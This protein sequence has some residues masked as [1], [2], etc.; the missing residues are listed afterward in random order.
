MTRR[1]GIEACRYA[2]VL[3]EAAR[4]LASH[5]DPIPVTLPKTSV[6]AEAAA[7]LTRAHFQLS[8][9]EPIKHLINLAEKSGVLVLAL[10]TNLAGR[11]SFSLW[12]E[13]QPVIALSRG[14]PGDRLRLSVAHEL[15]H[16]VMSHHSHWSPENERD[17]YRFGAELLMPRDAFRRELPTPVT[18]SG[19]AM[20]KPRWKVSV[21]AMIR[22]AY[23]LNIISERQ[24]RYLFEQLSIRGWRSK[25][26]S[27]LDVPSEKPRALRQMAELIYGN[28][29][30]YP[31]LAADLNMRLESVREIMDGYAEA[32]RIGKQ[33]REN[34]IRFSRA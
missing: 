6:D 9:E 26:P 19:I 16:L 22:R 2:E 4:A 14:K 33:T 24:Y 28:P 8:K 27:N 25:E 3:Y 15:G 21:Q 11:E 7:T 23:D 34:L 17:A 31:G 5:V 18:L 12:V 30:N 32:S 13:R 20:L 1:Q 29:I 10:P